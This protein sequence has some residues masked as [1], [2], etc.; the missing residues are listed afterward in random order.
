LALRDL[1]THVGLRGWDQEQIG[2]VGY[3]FG[4]RVA[5]LAAAELNVGAAVSVSPD[6]VTRAADTRPALMDTARPVVTPWL[7]MFGAND[8]AA[9]RHAILALADRLTEPSPAYTEFVTYPGVVGDFFYESAEVLGSAAMF[10]S[11]Q[12]VIEWLNLRVVPRPSPYA[13]IWSL[14]ETMS[15]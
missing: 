2:I 13:E 4:G 8:E 11:W 9:P 5:L 7:G 12:R 10:D 14:R 15:G 3:G 1:V 6:G